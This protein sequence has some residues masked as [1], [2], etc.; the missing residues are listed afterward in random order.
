M[1]S[2]FGAPALSQFRLDQLLRS[3]KTQEPRVTTLSSRWIHFVDASSDLSDR[4]LK[5]LETL[6]TYGTRVPDTLAN[7][8]GMRVPD[9][10]AAAAIPAASC[11]AEILVTPRVGTESPWSSKATDILH[12]CGLGKVAR[13]ERG[14]VYFIGSAAAL[15]ASKLKQLAVHLYDRMTESIW[16][17]SIEPA[18]LFHRAAPRALRRVILGEQPHAALA[19]A[20]QEWGLALSSDEIDYLVQAFRR[21]G[22][23]PTDVELM[24]FAQAN[25]EHCRHKIF[26][27][28]F[29][30]DGEA[31]PQSLFG[32]IRATHARS[33]A[34]VLSAYRDNAAVI[35]GTRTTRFFADPATQ[36]YTGACEQLDILMKVETH[37]HPTAISP[38]PGAATGA[39]GEIRDEGATCLLYTSP[40]PRDGLL[41]RMPSSA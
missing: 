26:N 31:M 13:V 14:T 39:G 25:S 7:P 18:G 38:F 36:R 10:P 15:G 11:C 35:E 17:D 22:R 21:L 30:I 41:S 33:P 8:D 2:L 4:E 24:M 3:L 27:A 40:S 23:D 29:I 20:N 12:V 5:L 6:L 19:R 1:F 28:D 9:M 37:N 16:V 32:M 34:G